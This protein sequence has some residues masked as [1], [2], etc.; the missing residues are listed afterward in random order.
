MSQRAATTSLFYSAAIL[1]PHD[2]RNTCLLE[3]TYIKDRQHFNT[4]LFNQINTNKLQLSRLSNSVLIWRNEDKC[5]AYFY[6]F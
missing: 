2:V 3:H 6:Y 1:K 4:L 5:V